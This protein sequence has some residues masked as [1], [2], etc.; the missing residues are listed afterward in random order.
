MV[1]TTHAGVPQKVDKVLW[2]PNQI[3]H[4]PPVILPHAPSPILHPSQTNSL[5]SL[6]ILGQAL[7]LP[8][9][10]FSLICIAN[11]YS[12]FLR[13]LLITSHL[14]PHPYELIAAI[15]CSRTIQDPTPLSNSAGWVRGHYFPLSTWRGFCSDFLSFLFLL[16]LF[17]DGLT[18]R[19]M[20][21]SELC[22]G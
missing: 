12:S 13:C 18:T 16:P 9:V 4:P 21:S 14:H 8:N 20:L 2:S 5:S 11:A 22:M 15:L 10:I 7:P 17:N 6:H 19:R 1:L 3:A